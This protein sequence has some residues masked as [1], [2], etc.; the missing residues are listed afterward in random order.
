MKNAGGKSGSQNKHMF[1]TDSEAFENVFSKAFFVGG[2]IEEFLQ[3]GV[4]LHR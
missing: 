1:L 3:F 4:V 2:V